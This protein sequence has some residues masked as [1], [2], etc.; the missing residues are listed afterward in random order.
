[1]STNKTITKK[2]ARRNKRANRRNMHNRRLGFLGN[3]ANSNYNRINAPSAIGSR[4]FGRGARI[5][6]RA[7]NSVLVSHCEFVQDVYSSTG[8][9][10]TQ[11]AI[12]PGVVNSFPWLSSIAQ[13]Y[14]SY[15]FEACS[16]IY[17]PKCSTSTPGT[18]I[19]AMD[20]DA[21]D[22]AP[23]TKL[24][25]MTGPFA[26]TNSWA[27][28]T[29][30]CQK[31]ALAKLKQRYIRTD[32]P[33]G[34][35][36][37]KLYD[38]G[39]LNLCTAGQV[40][41][42]STLGELHVAYTIRFYTPQLHFGITNIL[43]SE[44]YMNLTGVASPSS[45]FGSVADAVTYAANSPYVW[46]A[47]ALAFLAGGYYLISSWWTFAG[48]GSGIDINTTTGGD[49]NILNIER[50]NAMVPSTSEGKTGMMVVVYTPPGG[51]LA[52]TGSTVG[53]APTI[54][55]VESVVTPINDNTASVSVPNKVIEFN[56]MTKEENIK[57]W[58]IFMK[59][60]P[61]LKIFPKRIALLEKEPDPQEMDEPCFEVPHP[62]ESSSDEDVPMP[63]Q[64][65]PT[66]TIPNDEQL[67]QE[68]HEL[69][70]V[71]KAFKRL[72]N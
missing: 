31:S 66:V 68:E 69:K 23:T 28:V 4:R 29:L 50:S 51:T 43:S 7:N 39:N 61:K 27:P 2:N 3:T 11:I 71:L 52:V 70:K 26:D 35:V 60:Y 25:A 34:T 14:E 22:Q 49:L 30:H 13:A 17:K 54:N 5:T 42:D 58:K 20:Y 32:T 10:A 21:S 24:M 62:N 45:M 72:S 47:G 41:E 1:M 59:R 65:Q 12:N 64:M 55:R 48:G 46:I 56:K 67:D 44:A 38:T 18:V 37:I 8:F 19:M 6:Q 40:D 15:R 53:A 16:F 33:P 36:D 9:V 63:Y 57:V